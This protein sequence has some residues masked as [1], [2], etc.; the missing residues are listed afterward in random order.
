MQF[1]ANLHFCIK[2]NALIRGFGALIFWIMAEIRDLYI[3]ICLLCTIDVSAF[4]SQRKA[5][6]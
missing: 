3:F 4:Q 1:E 5:K 6:I 2:F